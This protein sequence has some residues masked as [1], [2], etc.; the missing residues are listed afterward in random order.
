MR[1]VTVTLTCRL[2]AAP[3]P[4]GWLG[5]SS[6]TTWQQHALGFAIAPPPLQRASTSIE[7]LETASENRGGGNRMKSWAPGRLARTYGVR[8][9]VAMENTTASAARH[10]AGRTRALEFGRPIARCAVGMRAT[11]SPAAVA[12]GARALAALG[13][14]GTHRKK[15][16][17][18]AGEDR[19][20]ETKANCGQVSGTED[21]E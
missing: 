2:G 20:C 11:A 1:A 6:A 7:R 3:L 13:W 21:I 14:S 5:R 16:A 15:T 10:A 12:L 9:T 18:A 4:I 8:V 17:H 19:R